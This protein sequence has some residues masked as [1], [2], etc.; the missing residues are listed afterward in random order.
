MA[1]YTDMYKNA[2]DDEL[3]CAAVVDLPD[4]LRSV[5]TK[6]NREA[7]SKYLEIHPEIKKQFEEKGQYSHGVP[8]VNRNR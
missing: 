5:R 2:S 4:V 7:L 8:T 3:W 1:L 6:A